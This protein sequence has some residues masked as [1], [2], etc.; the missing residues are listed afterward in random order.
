[1]NKYINSYIKS[2]IIHIVIIMKDI[3]MCVYAICK[4]ESKFVNRFM[5][6]LENEIDKVY[7]LDT[8]STDNTIELFKKRGAIVHK[9]TY[10]KFHFDKARNDS[11][12]FV[13]EDIDV[14]ICLDLDDIIQ[15][16]FSEIIRKNWQKDTCQMKYEYLY[17]V[18]ENNNPIITF[19]NDHIHSRHNFK[20]K[21]PIHEVLE[22]TGDNY[23]KIENDELKI[24]HKPD[25]N[26][27]RAFYLDLLEER[28]RDCPDD[29]RNTYL[30]ARE[31]L[32]KG[33]Y[34]DAIRICRQYLNIKNLRY[35]P[36]RA[37]ILYYLAKSYRLLEEY[38]KARIWA[39]LSV[40][41]LPKNRDIYVE[42]MIIYYY[43]K[44]FDKA[45]EMGNK[46]L[47]I[48]TKNPGIINDS[49]SFD[50]TINDYLSLAYYYKGDYKKAI[51]EIEETIKLNPNSKRL[52]DN[53]KLYERKLQEK[54][55]EEHQ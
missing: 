44:D 30:L 1:M 28:V 25:H 47:S 32:N 14:C 34:E 17:T 20:W 10:K 55:E 38:D 51:E 19:Y 13:P 41:E 54:K 5:D 9:R 15:P 22:Y 7:I 24:I 46:A 35:R 52:Q 53:K 49:S 50:G 39:N 3:K 23:H 43:K 27:S 36:E 31:Y 29:T 21:Y 33:R 8:G 16:G 42:L 40:D 6:S 4:N 18:D 48:K 2:V 45:I 12:K 37:K 26:K 11:L